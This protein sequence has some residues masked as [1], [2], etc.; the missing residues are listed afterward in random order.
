MAAKRLKIWV[1]QVDPDDPS[2]VDAY[3]L[4]KM[5][6]KQRVSLQAVLANIKQQEFAV[7]RSST[8]NASFW[9]APTSNFP[10]VKWHVVGSKI[11]RQLFPKCMF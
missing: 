11:T 6:Q 8:S 3:L 2:H 5:Q 1:P 7:E 9:L 4:A 10:K